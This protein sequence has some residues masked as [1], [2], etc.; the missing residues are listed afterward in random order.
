MNIEPVA[1]FKSPLKEKFGIPRQAG[2]VSSLSGEVRFVAPYDAPEALRGLEEFD[3]CWLVWGFSLNPVAEFKPTVR[4][5]R[6]GGNKRVGVFASRSPFRPNGL[7]LSCV[8]IE[9]IDNGSLFVSGA[10]LADGSPVYDV[11]PYIEYADSRVGIRSGFVDYTTWSPL[12]VQIPEHIVSELG[13]HKAAVLTDLLAQDPRPQYQDNPE[14]VYGLIFAPYNIKFRAEG[15][16]V[17]V[18]SIEK[19]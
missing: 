3:Y 9:R 14:R 8:K 6:L 12:E 10:D 1:F 7:G 15:Q 13:A 5:P 4:P 11:K 19:C 16:K 2:L 18:L 17:F